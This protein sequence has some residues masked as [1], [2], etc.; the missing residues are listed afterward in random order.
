VCRITKRKC[1][2]FY[3][4]EGNVVS[5]PNYAKYFNPVQNTGLKWLK[6]EILAEKL[7]Q[8]KTIFMPKSI[9]GLKTNSPVF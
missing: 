4:A 9:V 1:C 6:I 3:G 7:L 2:S 8:S 5:L